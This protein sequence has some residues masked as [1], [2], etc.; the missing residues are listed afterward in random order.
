MSAKAT[1]VFSSLSLLL[2]SGVLTS[3]GPDKPPTQD[4]AEALTRPGAK[5]GEVS[6]A[7]DMPV[8]PKDALYTI[9][10]QVLAGPDHIERARQLRQALRVSTSLKDWYL[11][12][13][14]DQ[15]T[16]YYGFYRTI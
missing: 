4:R 13:G 6:A 14:A 12:H 5:P 7:S 16:L 9:Y 15:S 2:L 8:P 1:V 11:I 3:C 10:C